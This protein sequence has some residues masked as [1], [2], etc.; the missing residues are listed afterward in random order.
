MS[1]IIYTA[2]GQK[3]IVTNKLYENMTN[4]QMTTPVIM[5]PSVTTPSVTAPVSTPIKK[6]ILSNPTITRDFLTLAGNLKLAGSVQATN[7]YKEDGTRVKSVTKLE[8]PDDI[9]Y[10]NKNLGIGVKNPCSKLDVNGTVKI[11]N[12]SKKTTLSIESTNDARIKFKSNNDKMKNIYMVNKNGNY[13]ILANNNKELFEV[14]KQ[15]DII[16]N[17]NIVIKNQDGSNV[18]IR[19]INNGFSM[20]NNLGNG[21]IVNNNDI[22]YVQNKKQLSLFKNTQMSLDNLQKLQNQQIQNLTLRIN[23]MKN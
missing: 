9:Y 15:G 20:L 14:N 5:V 7:Y 23:K 8:F 19:N 2:D 21:L 22:I 11:S 10:S 16:S 6:S 4:S 17:G 13:K 3:T 12:N 1:Y 18:T